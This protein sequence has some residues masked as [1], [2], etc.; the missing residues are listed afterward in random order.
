ML[1]HKNYKSGGEA[2]EIWKS[3]KFNITS[4]YDFLN[5]DK[6]IIDIWDR[7]CDIGDLSVQSSQN[8]YK[9]KILSK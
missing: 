5:F 1:G 9:F 7:N 3:I 2:I 4:Q 8:F 6:F